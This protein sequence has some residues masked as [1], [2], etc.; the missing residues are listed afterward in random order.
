VTFLS[1][2][3]TTSLP[4]SWRERLCR[5]CLY[6]FRILPYLS[7]SQKSSPSRC[8][9]YR[10]TNMEFLNLLKQPRRAK[11]ERRKIEMKQ[12]EL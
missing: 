2:R 7:F 5:D 4:F 12:S 10:S 8:T 6:L 9:L 11:V 1:E 3:K